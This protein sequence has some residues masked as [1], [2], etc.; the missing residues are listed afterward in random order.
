MSSNRKDARWMLADIL[1][2]SLLLA[3]TP[4]YDVQA[5]LL[6]IAEQALEFVDSREAEDYLAG[7]WRSYIV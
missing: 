6:S 3:E 5:R 2:D 1:R 7:R 4:G